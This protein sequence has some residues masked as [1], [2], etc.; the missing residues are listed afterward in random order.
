MLASVKQ[1]PDV[2]EPEVPGSGQSRDGQ[3]DDDDDNSLLNIS[4]SQALGH[5]S[6]VY[7]LIYHNLIIV[8]NSFHYAHEEN[9][10][11]IS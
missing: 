4:V 6:D 9:G 1:W 5:A 8:G 11:H 3:S 2:R 10:I 7:Y